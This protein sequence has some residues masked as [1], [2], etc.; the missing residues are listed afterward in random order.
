[1][2]T[3]DHLFLGNRDEEK[4]FP[5]T[6]LICVLG[7]LPRNFFSLLGA[8]HILRQ[9]PEGGEGVRQMLTIAYGGGMGLKVPKM[10][11]KDTN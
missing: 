8:V 10:C 5:L 6:Q 11:V 9:P 2:V 1:M 4:R 7:T 3:T